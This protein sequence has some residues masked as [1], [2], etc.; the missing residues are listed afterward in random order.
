[1]I[2][3]QWRWQEGQDLP[4]RS[5]RQSTL[6]TTLPDERAKVLVWLGGDLRER[7]EEATQPHGN[8]ETLTIGMEQCGATHEKPIGA[9]IKVL[10]GM[11]MLLSSYEPAPSTL[12]GAG[13]GAALAPWRRDAGYA[14]L[15]C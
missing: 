9:G 5:H 14:V 4:C 1:L 11:D 13:N 12:G 2:L 8:V 15:S 3:P 10:D 6:A 7:V